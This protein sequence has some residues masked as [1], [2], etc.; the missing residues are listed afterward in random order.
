MMAAAAV[1]TTPFPHGILLAVHHVLLESSARTG[2]RAAEGGG[3]KRRGA[4]PRPGSAVPDNAEQQNDVVQLERRRA[5]M[6]LL[7]EQAL[8]ALRLSLRI[9]GE[10]NDA[11]P[12]YEV[13]GVPAVELG[14]SDGGGVGDALGVS[15]DGV[16]TVASRRSARSSVNANGHVGK[17]SVDC[18][19]GGRSA[20]EWQRAV[21]G[22]W[23][24][25]KESCSC[26]AAMVV[27]SPPP[28]PMV[29]GQEAGEG[30]AGAAAVEGGGAT[31]LEDAYPRSLLSAKD[32]SDIGD[33]LLESLLS[34][35]HMGCVAAAQVREGGIQ[36]EQVFYG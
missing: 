12:S 23:L 31:R 2:A 14:V 28:P 1:E 32:V 15:D 25:V 4:K 19:D 26:L 35:K 27:A 10:Y 36:N 11:D 8:R 34:L 24:L 6:A 5:V 13:G 3:R 29:G 30:V 22:A 18:R 20:A 16:A 9:V 17:V 7:L 33:A 21:V